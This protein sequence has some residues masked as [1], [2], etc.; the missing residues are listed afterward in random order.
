M[1][2]HP[3]TAGGS[4]ISF[5]T[6]IDAVATFLNLPTLELK[7][8]DGDPQDSIL[9]ASACKANPAAP[10][11]TIV[12]VAYDAGKEYSKALSIVMLDNVHQRILASY[13]GEIG[14][15]A[16]M[17]VQTG[18]LWIDTANYALAEGVRAFAV[19]QIGGYAP[20]CG[21][22]GIGPSR[23]LYV[24]EGKR[25][26]PVLNDMYMSY[27]QFI[28]RGADRC[29]SLAAPDAPT[30]IGTTTLSLAVAPTSSHGYQ[31]LLVTAKFSRDDNRS[32]DEHDNAPCSLSPF[33]YL[34]QYDGKEYKK[35]K[36]ERA[37][38]CG[39]RWQPTAVVVKP[40]TLKDPSAKAEPIQLL[41]S[42]QIQIVDRKPDAVLVQQGDNFAQIG[43]LPKDV[44]AMTSDFKPIR[45]W[46]GQASF[47]MV[48]G[49]PIDIDSTY[50]FLPDGSY[51]VEFRHAQGTPTRSSGRLY[52][53]GSV[54][55]A[56]GP[57]NDTYF[58]LQANGALCIPPPMGKCGSP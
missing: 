49:Y 57:A 1:N 55:R 26:R 22:G 31:D 28:R 58:W 19:D 45:N 5:A 41:P 13:R 23:N 43:W 50:L 53:Y 14:E 37:L 30:I 56:L 52:G 15:D 20:N 2:H 44:I 40:A 36:M 35:D 18:T 48:T 11:Q 3:A 33:H 6:Q 16:L 29:N 42:M 25:I 39:D 34:L 21:D 46:H 24:R 54:V 9:R 32:V 38:D 17:T 8:E 10:S 7:S 12:A 4:S 47:H 27:W 51:M